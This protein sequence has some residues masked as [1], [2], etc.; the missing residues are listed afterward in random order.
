MT[1]PPDWITYIAMIVMLA[2]SGWNLMNEE[3]FGFWYMYMAYIL[4]PDA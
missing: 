1:K 4:G 3:L 2:M